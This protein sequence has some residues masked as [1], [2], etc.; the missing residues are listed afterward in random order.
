MSD[1]LTKAGKL[2]KALGVKRAREE[3]LREKGLRD[4]V[5]LLD[6]L[7]HKEPQNALYQS[8]LQATKGQLR[9]AE[10]VRMRG[11]QLRCKEKEDCY[12][13]TCSAQFFRAERARGAAT[14]ITG[15]RDFGLDTSNPTLIN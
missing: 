3:R 9:D 1:G 13:E 10:A 7:I 2:F 5:L 8:S 12:H 14:T 15:L 4:R 11:A 6:R